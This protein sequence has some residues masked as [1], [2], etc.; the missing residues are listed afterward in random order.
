MNSEDN[1]SFVKIKK[2]RPTRTTTGTSAKKKKETKRDI[3]RWMSEGYQC[4]KNDAKKPFADMT[5]DNHTP[6]THVN[7]AYL[8]ICS[9]AL[10]PHMLQLIYILTESVVI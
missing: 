1:K 2:S 3:P 10:R 6:E 9:Y 5:S 7:G 4:Q 8:S